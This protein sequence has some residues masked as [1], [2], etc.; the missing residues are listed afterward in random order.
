MV[1]KK[2]YIM[3]TKYIMY[4]MHVVNYIISYVIAEFILENYLQVLN[5]T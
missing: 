3:N 1:F 2:M 4:E 5:Y